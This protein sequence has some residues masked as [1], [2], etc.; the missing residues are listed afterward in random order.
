MLLPALDQPK[1]GQLP[2]GPVQARHP[3]QLIKETAGSETVG[4]PQ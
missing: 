2:L 3:I 4:A 1:G